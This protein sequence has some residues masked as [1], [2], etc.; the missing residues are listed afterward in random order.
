MSGTGV[1]IRRRRPVEWRSSNLPQGQR[2]V[3]LATRAIPMWRGRD[4]HL[5][6][7]SPDRRTEA[8]MRLIKPLRLPWKMITSPR[9]RQMR[10]GAFMCLHR[11]I[12][13]CSLPPWCLRFPLAKKWKPLPMVANIKHHKWNKVTINHA[14]RFNFFYLDSHEM[15][16]HSG[17]TGRA[18]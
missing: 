6:L 11:S 3:F 17:R 8:L 10:R 5:E 14:D 4:F 9:R 7:L 16:S 13:V 15:S 18:R 12:C 1:V 2:R